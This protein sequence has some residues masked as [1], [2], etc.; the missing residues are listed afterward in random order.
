MTLYDMFFPPR[1]PYCGELTAGVKE[2][3]PGCADL[4]EVEPHFQTLPNGTQCISA[5]EYDGAYR[6]AVLN[7]KYHGCRQYYKP[8]SLTLS[9][10]IE[11]NL[12]DRSF[13]VYTSVPASLDITE[14]RFDQ[15]KLLAGSTAKLMGAPYRPLLTQTRKKQFQHSLS[16]EERL[17]NV[18]G[19]YRAA[20]GDRVKGKDIL[21]FDDVV[22]TGATLSACAQQLIQGGAGSVF[23]IA[24]L[25]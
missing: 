9:R 13:D 3:C 22:T 4:L 21:L 2:A 18:Q 25:W 19:L 10:L 7:F 1:C 12:G 23:C 17:K 6:T 11:E 8:F 16:A 14:D 5:F 20:G 15:V 24:L